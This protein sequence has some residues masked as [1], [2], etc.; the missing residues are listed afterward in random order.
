MGSHA[1]A[2]NPVAGA[3][4]HTGVKGTRTRLGPGE[5]VALVEAIGART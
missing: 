1:A 5:I 2:A 3:L 4:A